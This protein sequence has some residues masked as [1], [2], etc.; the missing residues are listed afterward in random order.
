[1]TF[2]VGFHNVVA[3]FFQ[4]S[5]LIFGFGLPLVGVGGVVSVSDD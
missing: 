3:V 4:E 1:M 5:P 2:I